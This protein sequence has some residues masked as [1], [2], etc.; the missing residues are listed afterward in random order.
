VTEFEQRAGGGG[1]RIGVGLP[2]IGGA[3]GGN[4]VTGHVAIDLRLIDTTTFDPYEAGR[5]LEL[6]AR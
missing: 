5:F 1:L 6:T 3:I 2:G 4:S